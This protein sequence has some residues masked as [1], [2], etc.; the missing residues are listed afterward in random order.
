LFSFFDQQ[1]DERASNV[2]TTGTG[3]EALFGMLRLG[4]SLV[5]SHFET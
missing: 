5:F 1:D 4:A 2:K 3:E